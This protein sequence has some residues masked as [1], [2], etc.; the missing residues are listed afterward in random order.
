MQ[1]AELVAIM[2]AIIYSGHRENEAARPETRQSAV[3]EAWHL[4]HLTM[5]AWSDPGERSFEDTKLGP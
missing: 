2:A 4:W 3:E 5:D 1:P